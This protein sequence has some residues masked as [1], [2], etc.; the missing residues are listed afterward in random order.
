MRKERLLAHLYRESVDMRCKWALLTD[1]TRESLIKQNISTKNL[2]MLIKSPFHKLLKLFESEISIDDLFS[3]LYDHL[4][5]FDY[6]LIELIVQRY[7]L[8]LS[9]DLED[10][11]KNLKEY[12]KRRVVEVP[13]DVFKGKDA[14]DS[15]LFVKCDKSFEKVI[16][17]DIRNLQSRLSALLGV[18]LFLLGV[19]EGC[20]ELV[21]EAMSPVFSLTVSQRDQLAE[22]GISRVYSLH[23]RNNAALSTPETSTSQLLEPLSPE[24]VISDSDMNSIADEVML[25]NKVKELAKALKMTSYL[26]SFNCSVIELLKQWQEQATIADFLKKPY[27]MYHLAK[28]GMQ[29]LHTRLVYTTS[30]RIMLALKKAIKILQL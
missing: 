20:T 21:F 23:Y 13:A 27:L 7:C 16:F 17:E 15:S 11:A 12:C 9:K 3:L 2:K 4:S 19:D 1:R 29:D 10:Y 14:D 28:I 26:E 22:M 30:V 6:N 5:F 18:D 25:A 24:D 8:E